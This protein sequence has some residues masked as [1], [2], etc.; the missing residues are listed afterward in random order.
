MTGR[1]PARFLCGFCL[2][3]TLAACAGG[4]V[5]TA[6][7]DAAASAAGHVSG[8]ATPGRGAGGQEA[9]PTEAATTG[10]AGDG[11]RGNPGAPGAD[12]AGDGGTDAQA[13]GNPGAPGDVAV[14]E[15]AGVPYSVLKD[16]ADSR[17]ANGVCTLLDPVVGAGNPDDLGGVDECV[18]RKQ[19]DIRYDPPA[20]GG[21]FRHGATVQAT[22]DCTVQDSGTDAT[23]TT[24][25]TQTTGDG[26]DTSGETSQD[27]VP[28]DQP[29]G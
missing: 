16:D 24:D 29:Q 12:P 23:Q 13:Q 22:V 9:G 4:G 2:A 7:D 14:F 28:A 8:A 1:R 15:E 27:Q 5:N 19:S 21:F 17:C 18:I 26:S 10:G 6:A 11:S 3:V 25:D 20:Q